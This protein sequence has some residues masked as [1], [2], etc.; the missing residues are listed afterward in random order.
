MSQLAGTYDF[1]AI[2]LPSSAAHWIYKPKSNINKIDM[3]LYI[4]KTKTPG[5]YKI[6]LIF[7]MDEAIDRMD[8]GLNIKQIFL[9]YLKCS[10]PKY[11]PTSL[12]K[13]TLDD[14]SFTSTIINKSTI[15]VILTPKSPKNY[16]VLLKIKSPTNSEDS[17]SFQGEENED[18]KIYIDADWSGWK[19]GG[20]KTRRNK[21]RR[22]KTARKRR[23][24]RSKI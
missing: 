2:N 15:T 24:Y 23:S 7:Y 21:K 8:D 18:N 4:E 11:P 22:H 17:I 6:T 14:S 10:N 19:D 16:S 9:C 13:I 1:E 5:T 20:R 12:R 3:K